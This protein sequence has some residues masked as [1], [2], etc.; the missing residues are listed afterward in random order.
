MGIGGSDLIPRFRPPH[1]FKDL[2]AI[3]VR[4]KASES[5]K[6]FEKEFALAAGQAHARVF[7]YGRTALVAVLEYLKEKF[8][9][10]KTEV[11]CP[12]YTC[13][14]VAHAIVEA[15]LKPVFVDC[16]EDTLNMDWGFV[17]RA[18]SER[19]LV[20][21]STSLFGNPVRTDRL[22][23]F[24]TLFPEIP[25][26]QD[27]AHSFFAGKMHKEGLAAIYGMNVSK[28][29]SSVFGGMVSTDDRELAEWLRAFQLKRLAPQTAL[30]GLYRRWYAVGSLVAFSP[31]FYW[32]TYGLQNLG[33][34]SRLTNYYRPD[35]IDFPS[36]AFRQLGAF[37]AE[38]GKLNVRKYEREIQRRRKIARVYK[39]FFARNPALEVIDAG[40]S[41]TYSHFVVKTG[42][43]PDLERKM[44]G[45]LVEIGRIVDY[46]VSS[47]PSYADAPYFG[48]GFSRS[49]PGMVANLP[50]HRGVS[51]RKAARISLLF[52]RA[53]AQLDRR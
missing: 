26:V 22:D 12:S 41:S 52:L 34:L 44:A 23:S 2:G 17:G 15:G 35:S 32:V 43:A 25:I 4:K 11:V 42:L 27:C 9:P 36:D 1:S 19:T 46:D 21:I 7:P 5:I 24:R 14:V 50:I 51:S 6:D 16:E 20:V 48:R 3:F 39:N 8:G 13:V 37:E 47:L 29:V 45:K 28:L 49:A 40:A 18:V 10:E 38:L 31:L 30:A 53:I 33:L